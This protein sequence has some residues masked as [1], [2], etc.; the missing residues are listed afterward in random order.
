MPQT[1]IFDMDG[2]IVDTLE[3]LYSTYCLFLKKFEKVGTREEFE[4]LNGPTLE[5]IITYLKKHHNLEPS[6]QELFSNYKALM[7]QA[8]E[9]VLPI[10]GAKKLIIK[11]HNEQF[12]L[13]LATAA[14]SDVAKT[15]L[16]KLGLFDYFDKVFT[17][18]NV[19]NAKPNP[20]IY[21]LASKDMIKSDCIVIEDSEKGIMAAKNAKL[22]VIGFRNNS[23][24]YYAK[25]M[26]G[27]YE[28]INKH[29]SISKSK[30][31]TGR[32]GFETIKKKKYQFIIKEDVELSSKDLKIIENAWA[33][34]KIN[35]P[36][37]F[38]GIIW[39]VNSVEE[40]G[41]LLIFYLRKSSY[42][43]YIAKKANNDLNYSITPLAVSGII[44][45]KSKQ[46][47]LG[48][49]INT[50]DYEGQ[51]EFV[52]A[53]SFQSKNVDSNELIK[54]LKIE[55]DEELNGAIKSHSILPL[56]VVK[57][58]ET[59][60]MDVCFIINVDRIEDKNYK[61]DEYEEIR[62]LSIEDINKE[63]LIATSQGILELLD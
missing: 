31:L 29:F 11:L 20:E 35:R 6:E 38:N 45:D 63:Q 43:E 14:K 9:N 55:L 52:P 4:I 49:R 39:S 57:D 30:P 36:N 33:E 56:G 46:T 58:L 21:N 2:V 5:E 13:H 34:F 44:L 50:T 19:K 48:K 3:S 37:A 18:D 61:S 1:V 25:D 7:S 17:G 24:D 60:T 42:K 28:C 53:G 26:G 10:D 62:I 12:K 59:N 32:G 41:D 51:L 40:K 8:Y 23:G 54:Q 27:V 22:K 47:V 15:A 16:E